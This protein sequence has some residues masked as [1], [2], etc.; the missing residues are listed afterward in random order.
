VKKGD[1]V[2]CIEGTN[3]GDYPD[4]VKENFVGPI[5]KITGSGFQEILGP[6][7][8][9][10][11][12]GLYIHVLLPGRDQNTGWAIRRFKL[13]SEMSKVERALRGISYEERG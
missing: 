13:L 11:N 6:I 4:G 12:P 1:I 2:V 9:S 5:L 8:D 3:E 7:D 10:I